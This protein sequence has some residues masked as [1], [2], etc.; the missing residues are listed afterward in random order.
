MWFLLF[1]RADKAAISRHRHTGFTLIEIL[2]VI[3][4]LG[5]VSIAAINSFEGNEDQARE[6][7]TR[8]EMAALQK[9]L[10]QFRRDTRELPCMVYRE[11][12]FSPN[13]D[14]SIGGPQNHDDFSASFDMS[15]NPG[16]A[17]AWQAWCQ[18]DYQNLADETIASNA[19]IM[20]NQFPYDDLDV[21]AGF[22][23]LLWN[24]STQ[25]GWNGPYI[26]E[27]GLTDAWGKAYRLLDPELSY[28]GSYR[29]LDDGSGAY[30]TGGDD[31]Y[32]C[33]TPRDTGFNAAQHTLPAD[34]ARIISAGPDGLF[35]DD[36]LDPP[37]GEDPCIAKGDDFVLCL[38]R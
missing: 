26:S 28:G 3:V 13:T 23:F 27:E 30:D 18:A 10:L 22:G 6:N 15:S 20:L 19:L 37:A 4:L 33:L 32:E 31:L 2:L 29:C 36:N 24:S 1:N 8:M 11:G 12:W 35:E 38:M 16:T 14:N 5:I 17:A 34:V 7:I 21:N 9:A 25:Q